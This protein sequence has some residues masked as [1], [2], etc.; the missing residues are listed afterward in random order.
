[1]IKTN[2]QI[3]NNYIL[4]LYKIQCFSN[5]SKYKYKY[6]YN[7]IQLKKN[8]IYYK[9]IAINAPSFFKCCKIVYLDRR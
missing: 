5:N 6:K 9:Y 1:M 8:I 4:Y 2:S 3:C 7:E